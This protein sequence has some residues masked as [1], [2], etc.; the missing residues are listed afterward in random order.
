ME[1]LRERINLDG[2]VERIHV[3]YLA[4]HGTRHRQIPVRYAHRTHEQ[5]VASP[6]RQPKVLTE[7]EGGAEHCNLDD[8]ERDAPCVSEVPKVGRAA[9]G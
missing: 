3:P 5:A 9:S 2:V 6:K 1:K 8:D 4:V 7:H